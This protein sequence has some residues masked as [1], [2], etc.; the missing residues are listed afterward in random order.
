MDKALLEGMGLHPELIGLA[1]LPDFKIAIGNQAT[2]IPNP[3]SSCYGVVMELTD[4]E[5][6]ALYSN[7][8][9]SDYKPEWVDTLFLQNGS[10]QPTLCYILPVEQFDPGI[11]KE[12]AEKLS[13]LVRK[14]GFPEAYAREIMLG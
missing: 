2:L 3:G 4:E 7:P 14:L 11:N 5:A 10:I 12:Y 13:A 9:V 1:K 8:N 6:S